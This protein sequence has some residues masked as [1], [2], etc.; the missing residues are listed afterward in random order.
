VKLLAVSVAVLVCGLVAFPIGMGTTINELPAAVNPV[1]LAPKQADPELYAQGRPILDEFGA[2]SVQLNVVKPGE[3]CP[4][5]VKAGVVMACANL[6][7]GPIYVNTNIGK[8][9]GSLRAVLAHE[10][11]HVLTSQ[12]EYNWLKKHVHVEGVAPEEVIAD[13]GVSHFVPKNSP[14]YQA[15]YMGDRCTP[16]LTE[17]SRRVILDLKLR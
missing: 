7:V 4:T 11:V 1:T 15:P 12:E 5:E 17:I 8:L 6:T 16:E 13:C 14:E 3:N 10:Y 2:K 9:G